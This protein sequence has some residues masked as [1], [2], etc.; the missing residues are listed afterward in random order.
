LRGKRRLVFFVAEPADFAWHKA[1][2]NVGK[3]PSTSKDASLRESKSSPAGPAW[4]RLGS[5]ISLLSLALALVTLLVFLSAVRCGF[6]DYDDGDYVTGNAQVQAGLTWAGVNWA[7]TT[8]HASNWHPLTWLS[9]LLD[10]RLYGLTAA[11]HHLTSVALHATNAGLAFL[12]LLRLTGATWRSLIVAALFALHPLRVESVAWVSERKDVL[13]FFFGLLAMLAYVCHARKRETRNAKPGTSDSTVWTAYALA[14]LCFALSL[15]SKPMFVT[16]P[17]LLLLLDYWPLMR[18][19]KCEVRSAKSPHAW[20]SLVV[21]KLPFFGIAAASCAVTFLVQREGG[22][23]ASVAGLP[24]GARI[25]NTFV[26]YARYLFKTIWPVDLATLYP[27]PGHWPLWQVAGAA[28]LLAGISILVILRRRAW[29]FAFVGWFWFVGTLVPVIGLVQ[30]GIQS[31]ADRYMYLPSVGLLMAAVW[32]AHEAAA[33]HS[34]TGRSADLQ[35]RA[36]LELRAPG[37]SSR[38]APM[39]PAGVALAVGCVIVACVG[40]TWRQIGY[41]NNTETLFSRAVAVTKDN[42]LAYNNLGFYLANH[43]R[44]AEAMTNYQASIRIKPDYEDALNNLGHALAEQNRNAEALPFY[45]AALRINPSHVEVN[46]NYGNALSNLGRL[47]E[48]IAHY[49]IALREKPEHADAHGNL[50][51]ALAMK[52]RLDEAVPHLRES[53]RRRP[54]HA[55]AHSNL[56]NALAVARQ[57]DEAMAEYRVALKLKPDD[58]QAHNNLGNVLAEKG[59]LPE[60]AEHYR[61]ALE[62]NANNPEANF[63]LG[64]VRLRQ[65]DREAAARHF[66][67]ALRLKPDY[68][69]AQKQLQALGGVLP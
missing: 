25:E 34:R 21:E 47:D 65:G 5:R 28:L 59:Q 64:M 56:G 31:M 24:F 4:E 63:N 60:A 33:R 37:K 38:N 15:M 36:E 3:L 19:Q 41:W 35:V 66:R 67:E 69:D 62:L 7:F 42:Y 30:V 18:S 17:F 48:A 61:R 9:H 57:L 26:S 45:E 51:V 32:L 68:G 22:A 39:K 6:V 16:L 54:N 2:R 43:G 50:G 44:W 27:H 8:G 23:V 10:V 40:L 52:G 58:A 49:E 55:G 12:L 14:L 29:P 13:S 1:K 11:G 46:N 20:G 53:I